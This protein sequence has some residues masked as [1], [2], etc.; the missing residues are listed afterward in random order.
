MRLSLSKDRSGFHRA[1]W[2]LIAGVAIVRRISGLRFELVS[3]GDGDWSLGVSV[4]LLRPL[5]RWDGGLI[6]TFRRKDLRALGGEH[7]TD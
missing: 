4:E 2:L 5:M 1:G 3:S 7:A 6:A